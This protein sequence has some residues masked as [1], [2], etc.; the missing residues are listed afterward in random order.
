M[1]NGKEVKTILEEFGE[2][3]KDADDLISSFTKLYTEAF[4]D[5]TGES[6][7][8]MKGYYDPE[9]LA[10]WEGVPGVQES[11]SSRG[12]EYMDELK[13]IIETRELRAE[14]SPVAYGIEQPEKAQGLMALLQRLIPGGKTGMK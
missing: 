6:Y 10:Q 7:G 13:K 1:A 14:S 4:G 11:I 3:S 8:Q 5:T 12:T 2:K 9:Y